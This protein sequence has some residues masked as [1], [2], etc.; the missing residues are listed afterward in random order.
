VAADATRPLR[1]VIQ[2]EVSDMVKPPGVNRSED[3]PWS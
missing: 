3:G 2:N 1:I